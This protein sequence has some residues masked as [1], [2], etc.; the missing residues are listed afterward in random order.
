MT[1]REIF[2]GDIQGC[3]EEFLDLL[4][5]CE[6]DPARDTLYLA[7]D[8]INRG[9]QSREL[10]EDLMARPRLNCILGN[11]EFYYLRGDEK[12]SFEALDRELGSR[13]KIYTQWLAQWPYYMESESWMLIHGGLLPQQHPRQMDP[14]VLTN[15]R[16]NP[17]GNPWYEEYQ[18]RKTTIFG[19]WAARGLVQQ[20]HF[21]GL[22]SGCV[23]G[24]HL[25]ALIL[26]E[27]R[28]V[29]VP[30]HRSY[31]PIKVKTKLHSV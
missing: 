16:N 14:E 23:Y 28:L 7:G 22:D 24:G 31:C 27:K 1:P 5:A 29:S 26:P 15:L 9:P 18:A 6:H 12:K 4:K 11:H 30:A 21:W 3:Y 13:K 20:G 10:L 8:M 17:S 19:H 2:I 25:S